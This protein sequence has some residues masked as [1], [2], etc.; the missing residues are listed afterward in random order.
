MT[1]APAPVP[2]PP[3]KSNADI[4]LAFNIDPVL[5]WMSLHCNVPMS[6]EARVEMLAIAGQESDWQ[7]RLQYGGPA[8]SWYQFEKGG[9][10]HGVLTHPASKP[11]IEKVCD[12]LLISCDDDTVY[13]AMAW[14]GFLAAAMARLLLWTDAAPL[15]K[16]GQV[17][18]GWD[19]YNRNW[20]PG[21][22]HPEV[23]PDKYKTAQSIVARTPVRKTAS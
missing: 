3:P 8:R 14:N 12:A 6:N 19:Y 9:G 11:L 4:I 7:A 21:A 10:V 1:T 13:E 18:Q 16:V 17:E 2:P 20:R 5:R 15:P 22:P 23:W